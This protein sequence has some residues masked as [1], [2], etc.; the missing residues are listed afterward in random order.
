[1]TESRSLQLTVPEALRLATAA[2]RDGHGDKASAIYNQILATDP[3]NGDALH[4]LG[5]LEIDRG[6]SEHAEQLLRR[7]SENNPEV[8][9]FK[10]SLAKALYNL[11]RV[12]EGVALAALAL[13]SAPTDP[14]IRE[15]TNRLLRVEP[16]IDL[17][18]LPSRLKP[19]R[20]VPVAAAEKTLVI[21]VATGYPAA[22]LRPFV[23]SLREHYQGPV[24][25][26]VDESDEIAALLD[27]SNIAWSPITAGTSHPVIH[28]FGLYRDLVARLDGETRVLLTDVSDVI[29]Q[30][31]PFGM[32][33]TAPLVGVLEDASMSIGA[34]PWNSNWIRT[35]FGARMLDRL[36]NHRISCVGTILGDQGGIMG[37]LTQFCLLAGS[38]PVDGIYGLDTAIHN[39]L[40]DHQATPETAV[41]ENGWPIATVQHMA[42]SAI[43]V[44]NGKILLSDGRAPLMVHQYNRRA[45]MI[46]L[47]NQR[48]GLR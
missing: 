21:G 32:S 48:Y 19:A 26:I 1:M 8:P 12:D 6:Q 27:S 17:L 33:V 22:T 2:Q 25:L 18:R 35:H 39:V 42:E 30:G 40:I 37:Y 14:G 45:P 36:S 34:C 15:I 9:A 23:L 3:D 20:V 43:G 4:L 31:N 24:H 38:L 47:V 5:L 28:R 41:L 29:F 16:S 10:A 44:A 7:A 13:A 11:G 46:A